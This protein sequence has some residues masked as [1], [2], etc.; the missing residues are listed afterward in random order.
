M[1][2]YFSAGFQP[3]IAANN[4]SM[5]SMD[6][7]ASTAI[8]RG[9]VIGYSTG[10][11]ALNAFASNAIGVSAVAV[12]NASGA[13]GDE[14]IPYYPLLADIQYIVPVNN[15]LI[16]AAAKGTIC[17]IVSGGAKIDLTDNSV[18]HYGFLIED[19]DVSADAIV[20][21]TY[22]FAIGRFKQV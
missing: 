6:I 4:V 17:D 14:Q 7:A 5:P 11:V 16:T 10:A 22:G 13:L 15:A 3:L 1:R 12:S 8:A 18:T 2:Q 21:N 9:V 19:I 20:A